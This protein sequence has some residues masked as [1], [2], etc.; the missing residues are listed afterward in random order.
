MYD[1]ELDILCRFEHEWLPRLF[2]FGKDSFLR[3]LKQE[4]GLYRL[5][6]EMCR[7]EKRENPYAKEDFKTKERTIEGLLVMVLTLPRRTDNPNYC[8]KILLICEPD[9]SRM[10][11]YTVEEGES[12]PWLGR[13]DCE[14]KYHYTSVTDYLENDTA[15]GLKKAL[16]HF[17]KETE[18][19]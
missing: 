11:F 8:R 16:E 14:V 13:W 19:L 15:D 5:F 9:L 10:A 1:L 2:Y 18:E 4:D 6:D 17:R 12:E 3:E 7:M